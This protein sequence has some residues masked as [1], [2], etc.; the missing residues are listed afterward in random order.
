MAYTHPQMAAYLGLEPETLRS[1]RDDLGLKH[2]KSPQCDYT[3]GE[4]FG[5]IVVRYLR[6]ELGVSGKKVAPFAKRLFE[7][8]SDLHPLRLPASHLAFY[9]TDQVAFYRGGVRGK[10]APAHLVPIRDLVNRFVCW[11]LF[12]E[13]SRWLVT[14]TK[15]EDREYCETLF[16]YSLPEDLSVSQ[17]RDPLAA[18][19]LA[20]AGATEEEAVA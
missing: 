10:V 20:A 3:P 11:A 19:T 4:V 15:T 8:C 17:L 9:A 2:L 7:V 12:K 6:R 14:H 18:D 13:G 16:H 1:W 5:L